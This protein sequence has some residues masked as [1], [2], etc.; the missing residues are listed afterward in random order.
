M[1]GA[2]EPSFV[3]IMFTDV[4]GSTT[5]YDRYGDDE[6]DARRARHFAVMREVVAAHEGR[7]IKST[8]DG[9]MVAFSSAVAAVRCA[10][11]LQ[12]ATT[13]AD[14][15]LDVRI[16]VDDGEPL[17]EGGDLYGTPV[18][19][20]S[21]LCDAAGPG[22]ILATQV[23]RQI[24]GPRVAELMR[25]AG[26][27]KVKG[28]SESVA[29]ALVRWREDDGEDA[30]PPREDAPLRPITVVI[31]DDQRLLRTGFRVILDAEPDVTV[32]GEAGDG[33]A[34]VDVVARRRPDVVLMDIRMPELDGLSAAERILA[35]PQNTT[36]VVM[37]TTFDASEYVFK[38]LR[39]GATGFLLKDTPSDRL[40]DAVRVA[41]AGEALIA[42]RITRR[43][44]AEFARASRPAGDELPPALAELTVREIDVLRLVAQGL[45]NAEIAAELVLGEN[46]IKT[47][48]GRL[49]AKLGL[50]DRVQA[51]V[52]AYETGLVTPDV[53]V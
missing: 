51:V 37:L 42:P 34:A 21:R 14:D 46:T 52:L 22:E 28:I 7:E 30:P 49:L 43:L 3:T 11:A 33:L 9:L 10:V 29:T 5:L 36:A 8:G 53:A 47:H 41:A 27:F 18:I 12:R 2:V 17:S 31:A 4:V 25:P 44:I 45:S 19:V 50:R 48:V 20:A 13:G 24:A 1:L 23:V 35:D 40:L 15:G 38:A 16:G 39:A 32:V 6:A 26:A